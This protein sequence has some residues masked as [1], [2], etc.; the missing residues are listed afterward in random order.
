VFSGHWW[1]DADRVS[2]WAL[3]PCSFMFFCATG[4]HD[5]L[6]GNLDRCDVTLNWLRCGSW[7]LLLECWVL[8]AGCWGQAADLLS[9]RVQ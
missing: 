5:C 3:R 2:P 4:Q 7:L 6:Y 9:R 8:A 1:S